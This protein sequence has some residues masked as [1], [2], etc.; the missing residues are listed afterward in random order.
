M[1]L[2]HP[3]HR[4]SAGR[5]GLIA[6]LALAV[7]VGSALIGP[8]LSPLGVGGSALADDD[9]DDDDPVG[10]PPPPPPP[11]PP[12]GTPALPPITDARDLPSNQYPADRLTLE[13]QGLRFL[14][15]PPWLRQDLK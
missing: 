10:P 11:P 3:S 6:G 2:P 8:W 7:L 4:H 12:G 9:D 14:L 13:D 1:S 5:F 15:Q